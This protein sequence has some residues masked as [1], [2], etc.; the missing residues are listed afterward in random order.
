[1]FRNRPTAVWHPRAEFWKKLFVGPVPLVPCDNG[2]RW[3]FMDGLVL[4]RSERVFNVSAH[5]L[6][7]RDIV[8]YGLPETITIGLRA[9]HAPVEWTWSLGVFRMWSA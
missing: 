3:V 7:R 6:A 5:G 8:F 2:S 9:G 1:M 4:P